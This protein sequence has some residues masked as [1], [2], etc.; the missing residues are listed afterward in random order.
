M[1]IGKLDHVNLRTTRLEEMISW[2]ADVLGMSAGPRPDFPF[3][4]AWLYA[5]D[6][7]VVHLVGIEGTDAVGSEEKLKLEHF[8][9][10]A[11]GAQDFEARLKARG[12]TFRRTVQ[13][14]TGIIAFNIWD[15]DGNHIHVDFPPEE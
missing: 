12:E 6:E 8:A 13:T 15:P 5:G 3:P 7:A 2:Y 1:K 10:T 4:G 9:F 14:G 11:S